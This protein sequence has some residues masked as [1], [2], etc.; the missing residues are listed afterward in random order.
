MPETAVLLVCLGNICRSPTAE[1][2]LRHRAAQR[3]MAPLLRVDSAGTTGFHAGSPPDRRA[4]AACRERGI[5]ISGQRA[6]QVELAD[7]ERFDLLL[8]MD[9]NNL[10]DLRR[11][12]PPD[13]TDRVRLFLDFAPDLAG[14]DMPDPYYG[15]ADG[16]TYCLN[17]A[18]QAADGLLD[19][20][21]AGQ[22]RPVKSA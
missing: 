17:A 2:V 12:A 21:E 22:H 11:M 9:S 3:G 20:L 13:R 4:E 18:F 16:F 10:A 19:A 14:T 8:A 1:G 6:R 7:F 5:Q 15:G